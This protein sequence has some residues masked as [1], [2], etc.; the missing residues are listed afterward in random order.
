MNL[1]RPHFDQAR[2]NAELASA[3]K[4]AQA[5]PLERY[6]LTPRE[7]EVAHWLAMGKTNP[8]IAMILGSRVRTVHKHVENVLG[9]LGVENRTTAAVMIS[10]SNGSTGDVQTPGVG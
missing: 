9:K 7:R 6:G 2:R 3:R 4:A 5:K 8:E 10:Q 1:L